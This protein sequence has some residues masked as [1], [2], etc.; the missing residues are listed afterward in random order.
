MALNRDEIY[1]FAD[2]QLNVAERQLSRAGAYVPLSEKIFETLLLLVRNSG[3]LVN[4]NEFY[5]QI[6]K[7]TI[8]E[9]NNLD[10]C[11]SRL[12]SAL[13]EHGRPRKFIETVR[14][15]GY[16][17]LANVERANSSI[18]ADEPAALN[19]SNEHGHNSIAVMPFKD[20]SRE[21]DNN[22]FCEGLAEELI[23]ALANVGNL[24]VAARTSS[25]SFKGRDPDIREVADALGVKTVLEGSVRRSDDRLR[26]SV[27]LINAADSFTIWSETY[28]RSFSDIFEVQNDIALSVVNALQI[29]LFGDEREAVLR[30]HTTDTDAYL[31]YLKGQYHRWRSS[32]QDFA[33]ALK[34]FEQAVALDPEFTLGYF[35]ISTYYGFGAAWA[36]L[37]ISPEKAY[38]LA[39]EAAAKAI[40]IG[41][42]LPE[43]QLSLAAFSLIYYRKWDD[44]GREFARIAAANPNFPEIHH[45]YSFYLLAAGEFDEAI[46]EAK[47]ALR[48]DPLSLFVSRFL[49][50]CYY[51]ARRYDAAVDQ[52]L[53]AVEFDPNDPL[54][55]E[56][57]SEV[58]SEQGDLAS[59]LAAAEKSARLYGWKVDAA[60]DDLK[61]S[62]ASQILVSL[63]AKAAAGEYVP[64]IRFARQYVILGEYEQALIWLRKSCDEHNVF[65]LL[66]R[67]DPFY[68]PI[69]QTE[70]FTAILDLIGRPTHSGS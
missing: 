49:G 41:G 68:D 6:W 17:F 18:Q 65:P 45:I 10:K 7:D 38:P 30:Q 22:Y 16:R 53:E 19:G 46:A 32:P 69:R 57:L 8:V 36:L 9:D 13:D 55:W 20:L 50:I 14:G 51:Y 56:T 60:A 39:E 27:R 61:R 52:L 2:F 24:I 3:S 63:E 43:L 29:K 31:L 58:Y 47:K 44:A 23:N 64:A 35:G 54:T 4:K 1:K 12:R 48:L 21:P 37:P 11:I 26:I 67:Y 28:D 66:F 25:F 34:Y 42:L 59:S 62:V 70:E 40:E 33:N 5:S 15:H